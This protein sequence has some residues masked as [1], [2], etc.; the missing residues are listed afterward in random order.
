MNA[1]RIAAYNPYH[2]PT[3]T[4]QTVNPAFAAPQYT[5]S[6]IACNPAYNGQDRF[7]RATNGPGSDWRQF[8]NVD[9]MPNHGHHK[10]LCILTAP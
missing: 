1:G 7:V 2:H 3:F 5:S 4:P 6:A 10:R 8:V 9:G